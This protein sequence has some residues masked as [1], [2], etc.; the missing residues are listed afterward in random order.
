[1]EKYANKHALLLLML[2]RKN[3]RLSYIFLVKIRQHAV[4]SLPY[5]CCKGIHTYVHECENYYPCSKD[6]VL[7]LLQIPKKSVFECKGEKSRDCILPRLSNQ[8][9]LSLV[10]PYIFITC[11]LECSLYGPNR[12]SGVK[13]WRI[14]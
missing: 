7:S 6:L 5:K 2:Y 9:F 10:V 12:K 13:S 8:C 4:L 14:F 1:M 11:I 3:L